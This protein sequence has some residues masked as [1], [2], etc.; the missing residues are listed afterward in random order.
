MNSSTPP[1]KPS[2]ELR[3]YAV[4]V[5]E[6]HK[7]EA[8][9]KS[10]EEAEAQRNEEE[11]KAEDYRARM[12][13][14]TIRLTRLLETIPDA[15]KAE[16]LSL[17]HLRQRLTGRTQPTARAGDVGMALRQLEWRPRRNWKTRGTTGVPALWF[18]PSPMEAEV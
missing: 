12:V 6:W 17:E 14:L 9:R 3:R 16:G 8:I 5:A 10:A 7:Q 13:P 18:P 4:R 11:A 2:A 15:V 1:Q